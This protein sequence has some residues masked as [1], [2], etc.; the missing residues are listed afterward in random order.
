[1][2]SSFNLVALGFSKSS[3]LFF[4]GREYSSV[5]CFGLSTVS[6]EFEVGLRLGL[7]LRLEYRISL[8]RFS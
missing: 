2:S 5:N 1:M 7:M 3:L 4:F 8:A 6:M